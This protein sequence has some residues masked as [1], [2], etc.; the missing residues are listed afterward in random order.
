MAADSGVL[1]GSDP[2]KRLSVDLTGTNDLR[3]VVTDAGDGKNYD[4]ADWAAP[5]LTCA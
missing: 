2:A 5:I 1:R 4:H 3:L